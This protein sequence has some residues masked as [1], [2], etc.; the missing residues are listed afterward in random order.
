MASEMEVEIINQLKGMGQAVGLLK[1]ELTGVKGA[2]RDMVAE[3]MKGFTAAGVII[4][5]ARHHMEGF[6]HEVVEVGHALRGMGGPLAQIAHHLTGGFRF[7]GGLMKVALAAGALGVAWEVLNKISETNVERVNAQTEAIQKYE[8]ALYE[9]EKKAKGAKLG[10]AEGNM[11]ELALGEARGGESAKARAS[12][13]SDDGVTSEKDAQTAAAASYNLK[14]KVQV[15]AMQVARV[16]AMTKEMSATSAIEAMHDPRM[17]ALL[18]SKTL[19]NDDIASRLILQKRDMAPTAANR[20]S[21]KAE[22]ERS[23]EPKPGS[24]L[25]GTREITDIRNEGVRAGNAT[26]TSG[27]AAA[28]AKKQTETITDPKVEVDKEHTRAMHEHS[29]ALGKAAQAEL[30][31]VA[32]VADLAYKMGIGEG[33]KATQQA[34]FID[35][36]NKAAGKGFHETPIIRK[37][38]RPLNPIVPLEND[39]FGAGG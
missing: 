32:A 3:M 6:K 37:S 9:A 27:E 25:G 29:D 28:E 34:D 21:V 5:E 12:Y 24:I 31:L 13:L 2:Q 17:Q 22:I 14:E 35:R 18:G 23:K 1:A 7:E 8:N 10:I 38:V 19:S 33:S 30:T 20:D 36:E 4:P 11:D 16:I 26:I 39:G 15:R